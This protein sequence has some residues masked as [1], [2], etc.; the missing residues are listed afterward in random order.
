MGELTGRSS[1]PSISVILTAYGR[2]DFLRAALGSVACQDFDLS[3]AELVVVTDL[4]E[5][6]T[7]NQVSNLIQGSEIAV[8]T[9]YPGPIPLGQSHYAAMRACSGEVV[10]FLND[11]DMWER[12]RLKVISG[13]FASDPELG[14]FHNGQS[15]VDASGRPSRDG[16][17]FS[18]FKHPSGFFK[19]HDTKLSSEYLVRHPWILRQF[20][21][22]FNSS[23][24]ALRPA[25]MH[26]LLERLAEITAMDDT[27]YLY[28][29]LASGASLYLT[30][31]PLTLYRLHGK[32]V[33]YQSGR[34]RSSAAARAT[35][36]SGRYLADLRRF[37]KIFLESG[38][39]DVP[40]LLRRDRAYLEMI[41]RLL[42]PRGSR[43]SVGAHMLEMLR[44][45]R[46]ALTWKWLISEA[47]A[48]TYLV[49][50]G[51]V[52]KVYSSS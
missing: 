19:R 49:S 6:R 45:P 29:A 48:L 28:S 9:I 52:R 11:D 20:E 37:E 30:S 24:I 10:T 50:P 33:S 14:Y 51:L 8:T 23:S 13:L 15:F 32:N 22:D 43:V 12:T 5:L 2:R 3:Q 18:F 4:P 1:K 36:L 27:F 40:R 42:A 41:N 47:A 34:E 39:G 46:D 17:R 38:F 21:A 31:E 35:A 26:R 7:K 44:M 25:I 16:F